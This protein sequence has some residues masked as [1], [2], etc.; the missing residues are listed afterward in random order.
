MSAAGMLAVSR[1]LLTYVVARALPFQRTTEP[2]TK[3]VPLTVRVNAGPPTAALDGLRLV[4]VGAGGG[5]VRPQAGR[6][7]SSRS[8]CRPVPSRLMIHRLLV[9]SNT[10]SVV[11]S[12]RICWPSGETTMR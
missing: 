12:K 6:P 3:P 10:G 9:G 11:R 5:G 8:L 4:I 1:V 7:A 2:L